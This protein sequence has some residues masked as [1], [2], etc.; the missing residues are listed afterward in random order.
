ME[1]P[2]EEPEETNA[3]PELGSSSYD[4]SVAEDA[5]TGAAVGTVSATD[6][7][8]DTLTYFIT[9]GNG[10]GRFAIGDRSGAITV[11]G[12]LDHETTT[13]YTL[14]VQADEGN[15]GTD[16]ATVNI[17]VSDVDESAGDDAPLWETT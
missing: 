16:T 12:S 6:A 9:A 11:A 7:D 2:A 3:A 8:S 17:T 1:V 15:G 4:F 13:S 14:T 5:A 10:D